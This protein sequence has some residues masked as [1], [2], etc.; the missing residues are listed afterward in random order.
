[1]SGGG[2]NSGGSSGNQTITQT[3]QLP[4][5]EQQFSQENQDLARSLAAQPFPTYQGAL[6]QPM[7]DNQNLGINQAVGNAYNWQ[8]DQA[9]A[10]ALT[11]AGTN[12]NSFANY[13]TGAGN[14]IDWALNNNNPL[15]YSAGNAGQVQQ[16]MNPYIQASLQPQ[17]LQARTQLGQEQNQINA[18]ATQAGAFGDARQGAEQALQNYY[19]N[20]GMA[21]IEAQGLNTGYNN[22]VQALQNQQQTMLG[23]QGA[24]LQGANQQA[25]LANEMQQEQQLLL[26]GGYQMGQLANQQSQLGTQAANQIYDAGALQQQQGQNELTSAY[27]QF[28]NQTQWP[29]QMLNVRESALS[30][31]PYNISQQRTVPGPNGLSSGLGTFASLAGLLGGASNGGVFGA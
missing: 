31:S 15:A 24:Q 21:G 7:N 3:T 13:A 17:L 30:N 11:R 1:M 6:V 23:E 12:E 14:T 9:Q 28:L 4:A 27:N 25:Q 22:A 2:G 8:P 16:F 29:Y 5:Y 10:E 18:Q 20:Q 19:G 26:N